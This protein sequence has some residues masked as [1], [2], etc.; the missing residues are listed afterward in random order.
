M[1]C[2]E[3]MNE[4]FNRDLFQA[5]NL[6][7]IYKNMQAPTLTIKQQKK[8]LAGQKGKKKA[9]KTVIKSPFNNQEW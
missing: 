9:T 5:L 4:K 7:F 8:S 2:H 1:F 6:K 3:P